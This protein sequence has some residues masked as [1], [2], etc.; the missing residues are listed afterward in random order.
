VRPR[1]LGIFAAVA[2]AGWLVLYPLIA[3]EAGDDPVG[4]RYDD[5]N[6]LLVVPLIAY[7]VVWLGLRDVDLWGRRIAV[8]GTAL[9]V[10]GNVVEFWLVLVQ[11]KDVF[12]IA[13]AR[14]EDAWAGSDAGWFLFLGGVVLA[15]V[16][17]GMTAVRAVAL[18]RLQRVILVLTPLGLV[19]GL[20][21]EEGWV[22]ALAVSAPLAVLWLILA[23]TLRG[24]PRD[25][26]VA[27]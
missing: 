18:S 23:A 20:A 27:L 24:G 22:V 26:R 2:A 6:R 9:L 21:G 10:V 1:Y 16:G 15:L 5:W 3:T 25:T 11:E 17:S 13:D 4:L 12:A 7:L 19:G 14:G 8:A